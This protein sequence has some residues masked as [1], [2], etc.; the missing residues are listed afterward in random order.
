[1]RDLFPDPA[2]SA[3]A[4]EFATFEDKR[5]SAMKITSTT[6]AFVTGASSG[7]GSALALALA[8][9]GAKVAIS[10]RRQDRLEAIAQQIQHAGGTP[11]VV[12]ADVSQRSAVESAIAKTVEAFGT[13]DLLMNNA[14][15][16]LRASVED[17]TEEQLENL[18][19]LNVF[20][21][22]YT[23][24]AV[25]PM[26]KAQG[27]GH[28]ANVSS[29]A[30]K[31]GSPY[32]SAYIASKHAVVGFTA[33]LRTELMD[34]GVE[35][36]VIMPVNIMTELDQAA[37]G[38]AMYPL[39]A[40][41]QERAAE[42]ASEPPSHPWTAFSLLLKP[43]EAAATILDSIES[44]KS[45]IYTHPGSDEIALYVAQDRA[46]VDNAMKPFYMGMREAY[47]ALPQ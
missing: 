31:V 22:W 10:A 4:F 35:A 2:F 23:T 8:Q 46:A 20:S 1:M 43:E 40:K 3:S 29:I 17:T 15:R 18:F 16:E 33:A 41:G 21:L 24:A 30:G 39:Y 34:T 38:G 9:R 44:G 36:S 7:L 42:A 47:E 27:R 28:I 12:P 13:V 11:L 26:M 25:L 14:G 32:H 45:D 37:D 5:N 19:Q 6:V